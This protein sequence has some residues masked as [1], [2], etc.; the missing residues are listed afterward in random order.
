MRLYH[1]LFQIFLAAV[2]VA[3]A[4]SCAPTPETPDPGQITAETL[5]DGKRISVTLSAGA[6]VDDVLNAAGLSLEGKDRV[7]PREGT[8]LMEDT[9][10]QV[11]RVEEIIETKEEVIPYQVIRQPTENLPIGEE[12][13]LQAGKNGLREIAYVRTLENEQEVSYREVNNVIIEQAVDEIIL[14]GV[15]SSSSPVAIPGRLVYISN[16]NAWMME[17]SSSNRTLLVSTGDLDGRVFSLSPDGDWLLF[18]RADEDEEVINTL[19]AAKIDPPGEGLVDLKVENIIHFAD[20]VPDDEQ[21]VA[22]STVEPRVSAPGWQANNNLIV[23]KFSESGWS[24]VS[25]QVLETGY[26]GVYGWWGTEFQYPPNGEYVAYASPDQVGI[27]D[28]ASGEMVPYLEMAP[29][30]TTGDWAWMSGLGVGPLGNIIYA[31]EHVPED[32]QEGTAA[33]EESPKF[34]LTAISITA[35]ISTRILEDV[36]MFAYPLPSPMQGKASGESSFQVAFLQAIFPEQSANS[37]YRVAIIDRDGS[38]PREVFPPA[39]KPGLQP[40]RGWGAWSPAAGED[41]GGHQLAV[42]YEGN[43]WFLDPLSGES[44]QVTGDGR[45]QRLDW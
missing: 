43:I 14:V 8:I 13:L 19:W 35:G 2:L 15:R 24:V 6:T 7:E 3:A 20:W 31:V 27:V 30:R 10:I 18:T 39:E 33:A 29:Y 12:Q 11:I 36:G 26:I 22:Y 4:A 34:D 25:Y 1:Y 28:V 45:V 42:L 23:R 17:Q 40:L 5:A 41:Q 21:S 32:G 44:R 38:N 37:R 16:G 9:Q